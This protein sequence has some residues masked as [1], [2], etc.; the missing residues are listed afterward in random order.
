MH[1]ENMVVVSKLLVRILF[2]FN[3]CSFNK[4]SISFLSSCSSNLGLNGWFG[5]PKPSKG[6]LTTLD[7]GDDGRLVV[8]IRQ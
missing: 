3:A 5:Y 4:S 1:G 6:R 8:A 7:G 2:H